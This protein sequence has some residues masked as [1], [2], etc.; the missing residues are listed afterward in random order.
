MKIP[1]K[2]HYAAIRKKS[3]TIAGDERSRTNPG[4]GY[5]EH[6]IDNIEYI[7][8]DSV[9]ALQRHAEMALK[10]SYGNSETYVMVTP[11]KVET[12]ITIKE[13]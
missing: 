5:P 1:D 10:Y 12:T 13:K 4:H 8:F 11:L 3:I 2:I 6:T 7:P 9:E